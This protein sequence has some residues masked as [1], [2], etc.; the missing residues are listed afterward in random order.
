[1]GVGL[2]LGV[3]HEPHQ[4]HRVADGGYAIV[5]AGTVQGHSRWLLLCHKLQQLDSTA[6]VAAE[7][8]HVGPPP[9]V[10]MAAAAAGVAGVVQAA[11]AVPLL[12]P[13]APSAVAAAAAPLSASVGML[14]AVAAVAAAAAAAKSLVQDAL[15]M[16]GLFAALPGC[17][18]W[19]SAGRGAGPGLW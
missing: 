13:A 3:P 15:A 12:V 5:A 6:A 19:S 18:G 11:V 14:V 7:L 8:A 17:L 1:M 10:Q 4:A 16:Q 9:A 2:H